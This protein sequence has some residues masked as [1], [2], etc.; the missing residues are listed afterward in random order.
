MLTYSNHVVR[1]S[2][3]RLV[4]FLLR[5]GDL[6]AGSGLRA[7]VE[8]MQ[9]GSRLHRKIQKAQKATY[10]SEVLLR[11]SWEQEGYTLVLEGRAD[12][13]DRVK[14]K[15]EETGEE[16]FLYMIDEI[17]C[18]YRD[19]TQIEEPEP[20]HLA[21]A[22]CYA[23][24]YG[25]E[26]GLEEILVQITYCNMETEEIHRIKRKYSMEELEVWFAELLDGYRL[27]ADYYVRAREHRQETIQGMEF[28]FAFRQGQ[29]QMAAMIYQAIE[30]GNHI[31]LQAPTGIGKTMSAVYPALR[32]LGTGKAEKLFYLTAK[33]ITRTAAEQALRILSE[34]GLYLKSLT[35]TA[36]ERICI[37]D[38]P[39]CDP[40]IC[41][42]AAGHFARINEALFALLQ[43]Q[44]AMTR[45]IILEYADRYQVCPYE[46]GVEAAAW[47]DCVICDYNYIFDPHVNARNLS[48]TDGG[49]KDIYL[50]DEAHNLLDRA[51]DMYS[52]LLRREDLI[53]L[54][55]TMQDKNRQVARKVQSCLRQMSQIEKE[56][57]QMEEGAEGIY[58][59]MLRMLGALEEELTDHP[60]W[61]EREQ[62]EKVVEMYFSLRHFLMIL[63]QKEEGYQ[64][65][66]TGAKKNFVLHLFCVDPSG[67]LAE[68]LERSRSSIFFSATLLPIP[69][70]KQL[71][72]GDAGMDAY[73]IPS[74]FAPEKC[75]L[76]VT[77]DVTSQYKQR[78]EDQYRR[79]VR[80]LELTV[81]QKTGNYMIFFPSYEMLTACLA[82][83]REGTLSLAADFAVQEPSMGEQEREDYLALF[84]ERSGRSLIGFCVLGSIF[85]EGI[86]LTGNRLIGVFVVGTGLPLLCKEREIIREYFD[87]HGKKGY[88]YAYRYPGM[89]KVL[90]A[91]GRVIRT[92]ED[93]GF[94]VLMDYRFLWRENQNLLPQEWESFYGVNLN[95]YSAVLQQFW[96]RWEKED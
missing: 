73:R 74:P 6:A 67:C 21:Q 29:K 71:L 96:K 60:E 79:I 20:L 52:A 33:T 28:P 26:Q 57:E 10:Q 51:R 89:N 70:Y 17:K 37:L 66:G 18:V 38:R 85:S 36:R 19:V 95:N 42:R 3:R 24:L 35:I 46:L 76:A 87:T 59:P 9:E 8:A 84:Q 78:G 22:K 93:V 48:G 64:I 88:D 63:E 11:G 90:Q 91:A 77:E 75:L 25:R 27:W 14:E 53:Y 47:A 83:A 12:G 94:V 5:S 82:I 13:I 2:V 41:G 30:G 31:F 1:T 4:E 39:E 45:E 65:Y 61:E 56:P 92:P 62:R 49:G 15:N 44:E 69:Y 68:Y 55:K 54:K 81:E 50:I 32:Q 58:F 80:Y 16:V 43:E 23:C 86:D 34:K 72:G 40:A 7:D